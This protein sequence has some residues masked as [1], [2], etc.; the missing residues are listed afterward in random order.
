M[1]EQIGRSIDPA[2]KTFASN[3]YRRDRAF[4]DRR[5]RRAHIRIETTAGS[6]GRHVEYP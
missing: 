1:S 6:C 2:R 3:R 4:I 5:G